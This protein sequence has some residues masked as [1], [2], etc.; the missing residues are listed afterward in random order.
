MRGRKKILYLITKSN[1]GGAQ[2][3]V[4]DLATNLPKE[5][6]DVSIY[7]GGDGQHAG[8]ASW[9][10]TKLREKKV[11]ANYLPFLAR[12]INISTDIT[13]F[14]HLLKLFKKERPDI[15]H[16]HS[17]KIGGLGAL[18]AR[19]AGVPNI[20][21]TAHG[22]S[23]NE[24][25]RTPLSRCIIWTLSLLTA[26]LCH[27]IITITKHDTAQAKKMPFISEEKI[28]YIP[29]GIRDI[30]FLSRAQA[31]IALLGARKAAFADDIWVG[32]ISELTKNKGLDYA[33]S[34]I[35]ILKKK[36]AEPFRFIII[37]A[38]E[39]QSAL[40]KEIRIKKLDDTV[41]LVGHRE[42]AATLLK[43]FDIFTLT[44]L[45]E[46]LPYALLEAGLAETAIV[47][48]S[49]I[50]GIPDII[51][52]NVSGLLVPPQNTAAIS[53]A[54]TRMILDKQSAKKMADKLRK[55]IVKFWT[56]EKMLHDIKKLYK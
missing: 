16:L 7:A 51:E 13:V 24:P 26:L 47:V 34:A 9:L 11:R 46:G 14:F 25:W 37:G 27:R 38:G 15:V 29:N 21:F 50:G 35:V 2:R 43:A 36:V 32:T 56:I 3:H 8:H 55:K 48:A 22:W 49:D 54:L 28:A 39:D 40:E 31:R 45:K 20:I 41:F 1:Q 4:Y 17:S 12:D 53:D 33:L 10:L 19:I 52:H 23:F 5:I 6:F 42:D 18:A 30:A 44:S